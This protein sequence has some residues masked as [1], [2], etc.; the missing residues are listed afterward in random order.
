MSWSEAWM[1]TLPGSW[2]HDVSGKAPDWLP[3]SR[4][5]GAHLVFPGLSTDLSLA[6]VFTH[7][8]TYTVLGGQS[9]LVCSPV[10]LPAVYLTC[11]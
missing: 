6:Q 1:V 5:R 11:V 3:H 2:P 7:K 4:Y 10:G 8:H 9:V